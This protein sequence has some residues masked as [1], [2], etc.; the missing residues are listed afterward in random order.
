MRDRIRKVGAVVDAHLE[1]EDVP[2]LVSDSQRYRS[3]S[4]IVLNRSAATC[5]IS[6]DK[7]FAHRPCCNLICGARNDRPMF[8]EARGRCTK[9]S[10][11][12]V[13]EAQSLRWTPGVR[14]CV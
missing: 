13:A 1:H 2:R 12:G 8:T 9:G 3:L 6:R 14:V 11:G 4:S 7:Y 10:G 5:P